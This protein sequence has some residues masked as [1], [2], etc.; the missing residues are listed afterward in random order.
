MAG[1]VMDQAFNMLVEQQKKQQAQGGQQPVFTVISTVAPEGDRLTN[2]TA[3]IT[4]SGQLKIVDIP[5]AQRI[6]AV[7]E[8]IDQALDEKDQAKFFQYAGLLKS[9]ENGEVEQ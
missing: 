8:V 3:I 5:T 9:L 6:Q 1:F 2:K 4:G 7:K